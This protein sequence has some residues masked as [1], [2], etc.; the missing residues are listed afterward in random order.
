MLCNKQ[1]T[2]LLWLDLFTKKETLNQFELKLIVNTQVAQDVS[3]LLPYLINKTIV[4][5]LSE[6]NL[7]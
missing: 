4:W 3:Y 1:N 7:Q 6:V 5:P 2:T